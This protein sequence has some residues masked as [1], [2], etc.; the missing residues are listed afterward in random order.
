MWDSKK[1]KKEYLEKK[2]YQGDLQ[3]RSYSGG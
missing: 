3:Q 1:E 2:N